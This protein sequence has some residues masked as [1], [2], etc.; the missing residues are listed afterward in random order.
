VNVLDNATTTERSPM[1]TKHL[2]PMTFMEELDVRF[3]ARLLANGGKLLPLHQSLPPTPELIERARRNK[4]RPI[5][6]NKE[7]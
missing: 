4:D 5:A 2:A 6:H 7:R 3:A 1:N